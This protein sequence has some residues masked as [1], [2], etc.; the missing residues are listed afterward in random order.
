MLDFGL[1]HSLVNLR[2]DR[3]HRWKSRTTSGDVVRG[4]QAS[5]KLASISPGSS[6]KFWSFSTL[7]LTS[8]A[9]TGPP[10][11]AL[12]PI[13]RVST[14]AQRGDLNLC[15]RRGD[16]TRTCDPWSPRLVLNSR[17]GLRST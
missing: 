17:F 13:R 14:Q 9:W 5:T 1:F 11:A 15:V 4:W 2:N 8:F 3:D 6:A 16:R 10:H 7:P 12:A